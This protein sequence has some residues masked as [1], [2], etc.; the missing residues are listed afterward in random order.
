MM[1]IV[2]ALTAIR[3]FIMNRISIPGVSHAGLAVR[4][5]RWIVAAVSACSRQERLDRAQLNSG[6]SP[7]AARQ[8]GG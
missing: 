2:Y 5:A 7:L 8:E 3:M 6:A 4:C 1:H